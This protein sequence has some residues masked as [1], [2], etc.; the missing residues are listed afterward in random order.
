MNKFEYKK[1]CPFKWFILENFPF[2]EYDFDALTNWQLFCKIGKEINKIRESENILGSQVENLT[3]AFISLQDYI[4][5][6][7]DNLDVQEEINNKLDEMAEDGTLIR[8]F[9]SYINY[10]SFELFGANNENDV[11]EIFENM[12]DLANEKNIP[13]YI[14]KNNWQISHTI[15]LKDNI[16]FYGLTS[17]NSEDNDYNIKFSGDGPLFNV[18]S[19]NLKSVTFDSIS[20]SGNNKLNDFANF[21]SERPTIENCS[22]SNFHQYKK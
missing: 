16:H 15:T 13:I 12:I 4:N 7:F 19:I 2:I 17:I 6:Y 3:N 22:F 9:I 18:N 11:T 5:N 10:I 1:L 14:S 8:L 21:A 20:F